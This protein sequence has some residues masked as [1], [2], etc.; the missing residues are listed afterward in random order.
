MY[1]MQN[2]LISTHD[3]MKKNPAKSNN[4]RMW[5]A[6]LYSK[7]WLRKEEETAGSKLIHAR[8]SFL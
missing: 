1:Y 7:Q 5:C 4:Q 2:K 8:L 6:T 3:A